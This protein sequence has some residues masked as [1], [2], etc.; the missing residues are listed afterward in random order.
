MRPGEWTEE[1][2]NALVLSYR[3]KLLAMG[4]P[5]SDIHIETERDERGGVY[6]VAAWVKPE[7]AEMPPE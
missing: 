3:D 1:S 2:L 5:A 4:A 6:V 7:I